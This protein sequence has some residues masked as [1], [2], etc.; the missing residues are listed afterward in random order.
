MSFWQIYKKQYYVPIILGSLVFLPALVVGFVLWIFLSGQIEDGYQKRLETSLKIFELTLGHKLKNTEDSITRFAADNTLQVT[1]DLDI[2]PQLKKYLASQFSLTETSFLQVIDNQGQILASAGRPPF[3]KQDSTQP[4]GEGFLL[5]KEIIR[6]GNDL[7]AI[8]YVPVKSKN[9]SLG[10]VL[11]GINLTAK[12]DLEQLQKQL[13]A[14]PAFLW[15]GHYLSHNQQKLRDKPI[16]LGQMYGLQIADEHYKALRDTFVFN[17]QPLDLEVQVSV[18]KMQTRFGRAMGLITVVLL[19]IIGVVIFALRMFGLKMRAEEEQKKLAG[20][21]RQAQKMEAIGTLAGGIAHDFNNILAA[22]LGYAELALEAIPKKNPAKEDIQETIKA[23]MRAK[24][25][26]KQILTFSRKSPQQRVPLSAFPLVSEALKLIRASLPTTIDIRTKLD[27]HCGDIFADPTQI[28]QVV[29]NICTNAAQAMEGSGGILE[30]DLHTV[31]LTPQDLRNEPGLKPGPY[32]ELVIKDSGPGIPPEIKDLIF[33]PY[34]TTKGMGRG[35]GMGLAV[36]HGI[37][38][39]HDGMIKVDR[40]NNRT[41]FHLYFPQIKGT[42]TSKKQIDSPVPKGNARILVVDDEKPIVDITCKRL[43]T[44]GYSMTGETDSIAALEL[45][46]KDP[47]AFDLVITDLSMPKMAG[48]KLTKELR[49]VRE[50]I[51]IILCTGYG[52]KVEDK[53]LKEMDIDAI[54]FKP[55]NKQELAEIVQRTLAKELNN[56]SFF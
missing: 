1:I 56:T 38:K 18:E 42:E 33:D 54:A 11:G 25:L 26:V 32:V 16:I 15:D 47:M 4:F 40:V 2:R 28:H 34:F 7:Y 13:D 22:I 21:L 17:G 44:L 20:Q 19:V 36:V 27:P 49:K 45:F 53:T 48:D 23:C 35:S 43:N 24:E 29:M 9:K 31:T 6:S 50:D 51:P 10:H 8:Y 12:K 55:L 5:H 37:M 41:T 46:T 3:L 14:S 30:V 39:T 52:F